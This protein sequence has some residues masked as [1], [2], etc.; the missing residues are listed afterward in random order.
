M[1]FLNLLIFGGY[2][3]VKI[4][5][6]R[7]PLLMSVLAL[8]QPFHIFAA[9]APVQINTAQFPDALCHFFKKFNQQLDEVSKCRDAKQATIELRK[10]KNIELEFEGTGLVRFAAG[11]CEVACNNFNRRIQ[12]E[13]FNK[14]GLLALNDRCE[15]LRGLRNAIVKFGKHLFTTFDGANYAKDVFAPNRPAAN[16]A[17]TNYNALLTII[18]QAIAPLIAQQPQAPVV[19]RAPLLRPNF[20]KAPMDRQGSGGQ[21]TP[22]PVVQKQQV[23]PA[24]A[25]KAPAVVQ[26]PAKPVATTQKPQVQQTVAPKIEQPKKVTPVATPKQQQPVAQPAQPKPQPEKSKAV[27]PAK[28]Q[29][30]TPQSTAIDLQALKDSMQQIGA[31]LAAKQV[32]AQAPTATPQAQIKTNTVN[33]KPVQKPVQQQAVTQTIAKPTEPKAP[34]TQPVVQKMQTQ[35]T[36]QQQSAKPVATPQKPQATNSAVTTTQTKTTNTHVADVKPAVAQPA[37]Q[38]E[39]Q[40]IASQAPALATPVAFEQEFM[41]T[42]ENIKMFDMVEKAHQEMVTHEAY[43][44]AHPPKQEIKQPVASKAPE[45]AKPIDAGQKLVLSAAVQTKINTEVKPQPAIDQHVPAA[46]SKEA[47][48]ITHAAPSDKVNASQE[49]A[50]PLFTTKIQPNQDEA[51]A[52]PVMLPDLA[53]APQQA[54][55]PVEDA[56]ILN[57]LQKHEVKP[58]QQPAVTTAPTAAMPADCEQDRVFTLEDIAT[59]DDE[60]IVKLAQEAYEKAHPR[61]QEIKQPVVSKAL[62]SVKPV[63]REKVK[64][65]EEIRSEALEEI[66]ATYKQESKP[67]PVAAQKNPG[68]FVE[69]FLAQKG[70]DFNTHLC[71]LLTPKRYADQNIA[72]KLNGSLAHNFSSIISKAGRNDL[73]DAL[74]K[75]EFDY[76]KYDQLN[77]TLY[78]NALKSE[79]PEKTIA[80]LREMLQ[81]API[82]GWKKF[83]EKLQRPYD[84]ILSLPQPPANVTINHLGDYVTWYLQDFAPDA[85]WGATVEPQIKFLSELLDAAG[86]KTSAQKVAA[87]AH[88]YLKQN[89]FLTFLF[90]D[91][92]ASLEDL[93]I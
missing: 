47:E 25:P 36:P 91:K 54:A 37:K 35:A 71:L 43:E 5:I 22:Q 72:T 90:G 17:V 45:S 65:S 75:F 67:S 16:K 12:T 29:H 87:Y 7:T 49:D 70:S 83:I 63:M 93:R 73:Q 51:I 57:P 52:Q 60:E 82:E 80:S 2:I 46:L 26:Q 56:E 11:T 3:M 50:E 24:Q 41:L 81:H 79:N 77:A 58:V 74:N 92:N 69:E 19:R 59:L 66:L 89:A 28:N 86:Y 6:L 33:V 9:Q 27:T 88:K 21:A 38:P 1:S 61:E 53:L 34:I 18:D 62:E 39:Q 8:S 23:Q 15:I 42:P 31:L 32:K 44:K 78:A 20:A 64:S 4:G 48:F 55:D 30:Q 13:V 84:M 76:K 14:I 85:E 40:L 10:L 68:A